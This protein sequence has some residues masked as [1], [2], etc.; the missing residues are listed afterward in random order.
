MTITA[1]RIDGRL[2]HGQVANLWTTKLLIDRIL[3]V[4]DAV[5]QSQIEKSGL[6]MA[7]PTGVRLSVLTVDTA[8]DHVLAGRYDKQRVFVVAKKPATLLQLV[9]KGVPIKEINV[10]NMS[11][12]DDTKHISKSINVA[13]ADV[14]A[15]EQLKQLGVRLVAQMVPAD[16]A[17]DFEKLLR[18][19]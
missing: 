7:T 1:T 2:V 9:Q 6:R 15:F 14:T 5:A 4:D 8:A 13:P 12:S 19:E 16:D 11:Q 18:K 10:G 3:V 17:Q